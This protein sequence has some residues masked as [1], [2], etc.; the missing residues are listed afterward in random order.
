[1]ANKREKVYPPRLDARAGRRYRRYIES[2]KIGAAGAPTPA[3]QS[4]NL[5]RRQPLLMKS[6]SRAACSADCWETARTAFLSAADAGAFYQ[7][8]APCRC[9]GDW[10]PRESA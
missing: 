6:S 7:C 2:A 8:Y 3:T 4:D 5:S 10:V 1:M 9:S